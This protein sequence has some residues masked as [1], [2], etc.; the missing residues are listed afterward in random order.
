MK[1][2]FKKMIVLLALIFCLQGVACQGGKTIGQIGGKDDE[3]FTLIGVTYYSSGYGENYMNKITEKFNQRASNG[4]YEFKVILQPDNDIAANLG[5]ILKNSSSSSVV[6]DIVICAEANTTNMGAG[7]DKS[8]ISLNDLYNMEVPSAVSTTGKMKIKDK[9]LSSELLDL[10]TAYDG[11]HYGLPM[12]GGTIGIAY[13]KKLFNEYSLEIPVTMADYWDLMDDIFQLERNQ[14]QSSSDDIASFIYPSMAMEYWTDYIADAYLMQMLG[15][16]KYKEIKDFVNMEENIVDCENVYKSVFENIQT[17]ATCVDGESCYVSKEQKD[18]KRGQKLKITYNIISCSEHV[19][20]WPQIKNQNAM[21]TIGGDWSEKEGNFAEGDLGFFPVPLICDTT[22]KKV[23]AKATP[24]S[25]VLDESLYIK[26]EKE[27]VDESVIPSSDVGE[28]YIY[29]RK[30]NSSNIGKVDALIPKKGL[31][32]E[33]AKQFLAYLCSD[34]ALELYSDYTGSWLPY[35][36]TISESKLSTYTSFAR[37]CIGYGLKAESSLRR[38]DT[39]AVLYGLRTHFYGI[40]MNPIGSLFGYN[41]TAGE[42]YE[43]IKTSILNGMDTLDNEV[44]LYELARDI[45]R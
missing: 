32:N 9:F 31:N 1:K 37:D 23:I 44:A 8:I 42:I 39:P 24:K 12:Y 10:Y 7:A 26:V 2:F 13:N 45:H 36:Y 33:Y 22:T 34:E 6:P 41:R 15:I 28:D 20:V 14:N 25:E 16:V 17:Y 4:E 43:S 19:D 30:T 5:T 35:K 40:G 21:M 3:G 27:K 38:S 18:A 11:N 29:F